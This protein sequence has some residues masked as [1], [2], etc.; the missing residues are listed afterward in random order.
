MSLQCR[1]GNTDEDRNWLQRVEL[2]HHLL[3]EVVNCWCRP[4]HEFPVSQTVSAV[5]FLFSSRCNP[6]RE[7]ESALSSKLLATVDVP[8]AEC[9]K[10]QSDWDEAKIERLS[11]EL[12]DILTKAVDRWT[13]GSIH[14]PPLELVEQQIA[15]AILSN[16]Y[17]TFRRPG[18][19]FRPGFHGAG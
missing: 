3:I 2:V 6:F 1:I 17:F 13:E 5:L 4:G 15:T 8:S 11:S 16:A 14:D 10:G 7:N 19:R 12:E 9:R 18:A